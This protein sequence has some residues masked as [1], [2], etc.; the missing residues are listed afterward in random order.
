MEIQNRLEPR[1]TPPTGPVSGTEIP[2]EVEKTNFRRLNAKP[3]KKKK[4]QVQLFHHLDDTSRPKKNSR[5]MSSEEQ[6]N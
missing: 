3:K 4:S 1:P 2:V 6:E 5:F